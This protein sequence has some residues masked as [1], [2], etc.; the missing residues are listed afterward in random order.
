VVVAPIKY[1]HVHRQVRKTLGRVDARE[2]SANDH[3]ARPVRLRFAITRS[4]VGLSLLGSIV[5]SIPFRRKVRF[6]ISLS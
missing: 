6:A 4:V 2:T 3:N 1:S 5:H